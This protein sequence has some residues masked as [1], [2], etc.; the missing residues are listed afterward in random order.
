M[1]DYKISRWDYG[2]DLP[3]HGILIIRHGPR[4]GDHAPTANASLTMEGRIKCNEFG[5]MW[6]RSP[7]S[8]I[9]VSSIPRCRE[10]GEIIR[11]AAGWDIDIIECP[12]LGNPGPFMIDTEVVSKIMRKDPEL[13]FLHRLIAG[14]PI[15]GMLNRDIGCRNLIVEIRQFSSENGLILGISHDSIIAALLAY[16]GNDPDP[17][18]EPLCGSVILVPH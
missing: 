13:N 10:T 8:S 16:G 3:D 12:H 6:N 15:P 5:M 17:W 2:D 1:K 4:E 7:P 18:P 9:L 11:K 14:E